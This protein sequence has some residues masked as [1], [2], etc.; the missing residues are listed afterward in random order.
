MDED[1]LLLERG[2]RLIG[3][4]HA[5]NL[6]HVDF[7]PYSLRGSGEVESRVDALFRGVSALCTIIDRPCG[8]E[9]IPALRGWEGGRVE[10]QFKADGRRV[11]GMISQR[12]V[13]A[14]LFHVI[15]QGARDPGEP[16]MLGD[17]WI[18][19]GAAHA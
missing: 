6:R 16:L 10:L 19:G 11:R 8:A 9:L 17:F 18:H 14:M 7:L 1:T 13:G 12:R 5:N 2:N 3:W 15:K 4:L